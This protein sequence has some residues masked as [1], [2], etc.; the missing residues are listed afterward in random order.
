[1]LWLSGEAA[2]AAMVFAFPFAL[3]LTWMEREALWARALTRVLWLLPAPMLVAA[4]WTGALGWM[5]AAG[6]LAGAGALA[7]EGSARLAALPAP[8]F[9]S[10]KTI[11][12]PGYRAAWPALRAGMLATAGWVTL[13][14]FLE[15]LAGLLLR[16]RAA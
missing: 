6:V 5:A 8:W 7:R 10:L 15:A 1:M 14:L 3:L 4:W 9:E 13:R 12:A 11:G 2:L 16:G